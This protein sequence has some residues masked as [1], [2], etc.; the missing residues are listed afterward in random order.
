MTLEDQSTPRCYTP[1]TAT[2]P[3]SMLDDM[4][5]VMVP[6]AQDTQVAGNK[7][8]LFKA[9]KEI[10]PTQMS[11]QDTNTDDVNT[12]KLKK[13]S[14]SLVTYNCKGFRQ[15]SDYILSELIDSDILCLSETW[16]KPGELH[17]INDALKNYP[18]T[19]NA[20]YR[21]F[22]KSSMTET[23]VTHSGRPFGAVAVI[24]KSNDELSVC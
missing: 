15:S 18:T 6:T 9:V 2:T 19:C 7:P 8:C 14:V 1:V 21:V 16:L 4:G 23:D 17:L 20:E 3:N 5:S 22:S 24:C 13:V 10:P 12:K 11:T